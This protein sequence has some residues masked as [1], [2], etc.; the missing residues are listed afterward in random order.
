MMTLAAVLS[1][2]NIILILSGQNDPGIYY[3]LDV[4][5]FLVI[6]LFFRLNARSMAAMR[7]IG[8][9][10][11]VGFVYVMVVEIIIRFL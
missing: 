5:A 4:I 1:I 11:L 7:V 8:S 2:I 9:F 6:V 3:V 10:L